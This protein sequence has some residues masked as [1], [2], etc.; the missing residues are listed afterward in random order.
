MRA[1]SS[2]I[3]RVAEKPQTFGERAAYDVSAIVGGT[4]RV[5]TEDE[6]LIEGAG[7][8]LNLDYEHGGKVLSI[9][10]G[11]IDLTDLPDWTTALNQTLQAGVKLNDRELQRRE[12]WPRLVCDVLNAAKPQLGCVPRGGAMV[13]TGIH[14]TFAVTQTLFG[15]RALSSVAAYFGVNLPDSRRR[16]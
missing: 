1:F 4:P 16:M 3:L 14:N 5:W 10:L 9:S 11:E 6:L 2:A 12:D 8:G 15:R 7:F 13:V